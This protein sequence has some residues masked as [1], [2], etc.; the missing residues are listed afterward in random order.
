VR[1]MQFT[2]IATKMKC[3]KTGHLCCEESHSRDRGWRS[4]GVRDD[5]GRI[6]TSMSENS[7]VA[8]I[9]LELDHDHANRV[10]IA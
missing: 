4:D 1:K 2:T 7:L 9:L 6:C 8:V 3:L 10:D 5:T